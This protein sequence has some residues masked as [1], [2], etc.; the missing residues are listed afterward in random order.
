M[1]KQLGH[2][3]NSRAHLRLVAVH[4]AERLLAS[5]RESLKAFRALYVL[6]HNVAD[7]GRVARD[8]LQFF[9]VPKYT[10]VLL[11][12]VR[13]EHCD[14]AQRRFHAAAGREAVERPRRKDERR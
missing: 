7:G 10:A 8:D 9:P 2:Y 5:Q 6:E 1:L 12:L 11:Q 4:A 14:P 3:T 13:A